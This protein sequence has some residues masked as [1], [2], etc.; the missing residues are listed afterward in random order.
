MNGCAPPTRVTDDLAVTDR[1]DFVAVDA[2]LRNSAAAAATLADLDVESAMVDRCD[3][4]IR[5]REREH[6]M[7]QLAR[8]RRGVRGDD[9]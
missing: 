6:L 7:A 2:G 9:T 8:V 4:G 3:R 1:G 5:G